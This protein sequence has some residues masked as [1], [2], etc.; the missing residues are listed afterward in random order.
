ML[1][2][3]IC[4]IGLSANT[5]QSAFYVGLTWPVSVSALARQIKT[6]HCMPNEDYKGLPKV[7]FKPPL[8]YL[9]RTHANGLFEQDKDD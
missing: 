3:G 4:A 1:C 8:S 6:E 9:I 7:P 2:G 5:L